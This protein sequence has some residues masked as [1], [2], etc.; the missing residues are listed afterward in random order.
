[1]A[2]RELVAVV[3]YGGDVYG[4]GYINP[5]PDDVAKVITNPACWGDPKAD[6]ADESAPGGQT[7]EPAAE[8]PPPATPA[9]TE[10]VV[11]PAPVPVS[12]PPVPTPE[13]APIVEVPPRSGRG[14]GIDAWR[15]FAQAAGVTTPADATRDDIIE[16]CEKAKVI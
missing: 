15:A 5:P 9:P 12:E 3:V 4:P 14:S 2:A 16:A 10:P 13:P 8:T 1:M 7:E 6:P 11:T